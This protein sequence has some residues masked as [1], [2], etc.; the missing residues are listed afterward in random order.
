VTVEDLDVLMSKPTSFFKI[1][2]HFMIHFRCVLPRQ[3]CQ[4]S[5]KTLSTLWADTIKKENIRKILS[6]DYQQKRG[7]EVK[8]EGLKMVNANSSIS[9]SHKTY[10]ILQ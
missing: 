6:M 2:I 3:R 8:N 7:G 5:T 9:N 4:I 1:I 10:M